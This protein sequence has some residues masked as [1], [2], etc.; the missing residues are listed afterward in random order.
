MDPYNNMDK[1]VTEPEFV[2]EGDEAQRGGYN[3]H[4]DMKRC[5]K[6]DQHLNFIPFKY[7]L[8]NQSSTVYKIIEILGN[9]TVRISALNKQRIKL[10][11]SGMLIRLVEIENLDY[12]R[13][14]CLFFV[15]ITAKHV[16]FSDTEAKSATVDFF[17]DGDYRCDSNS[18]KCIKLLAS[19]NEGDF[20]EV[21]CMTTNK[22][23]AVKIKNLLDF[24]KF[25]LAHRDTLFLYVRELK[26]SYLIQPDLNNF[27]ERMSGTQ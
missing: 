8:G 19:N 22:M 5:G 16:I 21:L 3:L 7:F 11:A 27:K 9:L 18:A 26:Y 2:E 12:G 1:W 10:N 20:S 13:D 6:N 4:K 17:N 25:K 24:N 23:L 14:H 15:I